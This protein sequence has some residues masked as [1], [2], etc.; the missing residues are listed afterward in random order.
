MFQPSYGLITSLPELQDYVDRILADGRAFAWDIETGY[1]GESREQ[2]SLHPEEN[3]IAGISLTNSLKWCR[4][5]CLAHDTGP[6]LDQ[7]AVAEILYPLLAKTRLGVAHG[8]KF[9][10]RVTR[11]WFQEQLGVTLDYRAFRLRSDTMLESY[12]EAVNRYHG[13]KPLSEQQAET[14]TSGFWH[15]QLELDELFELVNGKPLTAKQKKEKR[16]NVLNPLDARVQ[17]YVCEDSIYTLAHHRLRFPRLQQSL[18][19][20]PQAGSGF[21]WKLEMAVLPVACE[22]EDEGIWYDWLAMRDWAAKGKSFADRYMDE[23]RED[24]GQLRGEPLPATFNFGSPIQLR[25]LLYEDCGMPI[26]HWTKGGKTGNK[27]PGTDAKVALKGLSAEYPA[28]AKYLEWKRL[29]KLYRDFLIAFEKKYCFAEDRRAHPSLVQHGVPGGRFAHKDPNY[30]QSPKKYHYELRDGDIF[31]FNFRDMIGSPPDWYLIGFDLAQAELRAVA[32][33]AQETKMVEAFEHNVDVHRVTASLIFGVPV[34]QVTDDQRSVGKTMGLA[35]VYG[36]TEQ[37]LADRLGIT[38]QQAEDLFAAFHAAYP[39]I[40]AWTEKTI[41]H[42]QETGYVETWWGRKVRIWDID[43]PDRR[44]RLEAQRTAGNAPVQG[45]ATGDYMKLV[46]VRCEAALHKAGLKDKVRLVMN[47]HDALEFYVHKSVKPA[48]VIRV[49]QPAVIFPV[50]GWPPL[51]AEWHCGERWGSVK[52]LDVTLNPDGTVAG[53]RLKSGGQDEPEIELGEEDEE[54]VA[55]VQPVID[56]DLVR[57]AASATV[58]LDGDADQGRA[59]E[60]ESLGAGVLLPGP[61]PADGQHGDSRP[62]TVVITPHAAVPREAL[63][64]LVAYLRSRPGRNTLQLRLDGQVAQMQDTCGITPADEAEISIIL[65]GATVRYDEAS[66][67]LE[68]LGAG[69]IA[70]WTLGRAGTRSTRARSMMLAWAR[71]TWPASS[72]KHASCWRRRTR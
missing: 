24:F 58:A 61:V 27:Q 23:I 10:L 46:M 33:M 6:N 31:H 49:L 56:L 66:V 59:G 53:V 42:A 50:A 14:D 29:T 48:E 68:A 32:G 34:D 43:S 57:R 52:E 65:G 37:G 41:R 18:A 3:F 51:L 39:K 17:R 15:P 71:L 21:I 54:D 36:L 30:A 20:S 9:E 69:V 11:P 1:H 67:D 7:K 13:L 5:V 47:V 19:D 12:A 45:S 44:K 8:G 72:G 35:L 16:F 26:R 60:P 70:L 55:P 63:H 64:E 22:M 38:V 2:A 28:V 4:Y 62:R 40:K 25:R